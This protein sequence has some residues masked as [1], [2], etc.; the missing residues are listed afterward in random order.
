MAIIKIKKINIQN[1]RNVRQGEIVLTVNFETFLQANVV[2]LYGQN[3]SGKTTIVDAFSLLK[4]LLSG[5][6]AE[7]KL[8]S[9]KKRLILAGEQTA[10]MDVEFLVQ[11]QFGTFFVNYYVE[12]QEDQHRLYTTLERL[13]YRENTK[14]KRSKILVA[15][16]E[17]DVQIRQSKLDDLSEQ[18]RIQLLV[19]QQLA[20]K[21]YISFLFHKD[22]KTLLQER[23][24]ELEMQLLQNIA[25]DFSRDLHVVNTQNIAPL[26]EERMMPFSIH[27]EK[28]RGLIPYDLNGPALLPEDAFYALCEVI[29]Q[30]NQVLSAIIPGLTIKINI[31][32][33]QMMDSGE[34]GIRFEFLSQRG[35]QELP[36][37]TESEGILKIISILSVLI[38]VY[39]NPNACVVIDE[40]DS[41]VF[42]YLLGE[43]LTV[44]DEDGKGQLI[45]TSHNL[46]VLEVLAI[47]NLWFT[48][49]NE[50]H[51]YMQLKGIK[52][53]NNARDVYLRA[54]QLGG[55][56]EE[57]YK[58][59]KTFK[60]KRAFRKAGVQHD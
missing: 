49:T 10:S 1:L 12:L 2:G 39:N 4:T 42:E 35:E 29:E 45:F 6:L 23:L 50:H 18:A 60:I 27:L 32:T 17:R 13:T 59:T 46:R 3:G 37:R 19:I 43:L 22:I 34:Q 40:L 38:A 14:G 51:R 16:T 55:Q 57:I 28:T 44:I 30:S 21:Q 5:W 56:E 47:K 25:V 26:F 9:Q 41:G 7:V 33:K 54:I 58:E 15:V 11:N 52:E 48:T 8:P 24:S 36:L 20:R 53:V 31:I